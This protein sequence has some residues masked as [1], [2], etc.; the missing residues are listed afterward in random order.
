M[1]VSRHCKA[2]KQTS[3]GDYPLCL[4]CKTDTVSGLSPHPLSFG[5]QIRMTSHP[6]LSEGAPNGSKAL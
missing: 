2:S 5:W 1:A 3:A 4:S 6:Q